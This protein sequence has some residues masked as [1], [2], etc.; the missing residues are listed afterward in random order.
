VALE[1]VFEDTLS[2]ISRCRLGFAHMISQKAKHAT[3]PPVDAFQF[4][5]APCCVGARPREPLAFGCLI[6][7]CKRNLLPKVDS[8][9]PK[10]VSWLCQNTKYIVQLPLQL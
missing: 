9:F 4:P 1:S 5:S 7:P 6:A 8:L 10:F 2:D 3:L